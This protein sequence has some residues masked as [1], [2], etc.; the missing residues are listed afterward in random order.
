MSLAK[1]RKVPGHFKHSLANDAKLEEKTT[2]T[3]TKKGIS[4]AE[5]SNQMQFFTT[6][7][8]KMGMPT[9]AGINKQ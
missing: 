2:W 8:T 4:Y 5:H 1:F 9:A 6:H 3:I 7:N